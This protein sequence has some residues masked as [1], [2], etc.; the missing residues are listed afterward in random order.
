[1]KQKSIIAVAGLAMLTWSPLVSAQVRVFAKAEIPGELYPGDRFVFAV[2]VENAGKPS[3]IDSTPL[4]RFN[5]SGPTHRHVQQTINFK[6]TIQNIA[7]FVL[8]A[9]APGAVRIAP[10]TVI[11][12]GM[13]YT[14]NPVEFTVA[15]PGTTDKLKL[16]VTLSEQTCYVGQPV[17]MSVA[18]TLPREHDN[19]N[20]QI[21]I[22]QSDDFY[23]EDPV[24]PGKVEGSTNSIHGI[25]VEV[26]SQ[27]KRIKGVAAA[28]I[29]FDKILIPKRH[30]SLSFE[31]V[32]ASASLPVGRVRTND[33][34]QPFR[35]RY[36]RFSVNSPPLNLEVK[37][38]PTDNQPPGY[39]GLVGRYT[40]ATQA[41]PTEVS[42][43]DPITLTIRIGGNPYLKPVRWPDLANV[44]ALAEHFRI[45]SEKASPELQQG[46]K[47]F[48]QT[49]RAKSDQVTAIPAIPL[50]TFDPQAHTYRTLTSAP[51]PLTVAASQVLGSEDLVGFSRQPRNR[52][53][54]AI[55]EGLAANYEGDDALENQRFSLTAMALSPGPLVIWGLPLLSLA[56]SILLKLAYRTSPEQVAA[57]RRRQAA[58]RALQGL[59]DLRALPSADQPEKLGQLLCQYVGDRFGKTAGSLTAQEC[60]ET[61]LQAGI[62]ADLA[63]RLEQVVS[64][65]EAARY[66]SQANEIDQT[67]ERNVQELIKTIDRAAKRI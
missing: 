38:L 56:G 47:V 53:V 28:V 27:T 36:Q 34:F 48:T 30:G 62:A 8:T 31:P 25:P 49:I 45:P 32:T 18:W 37:A 22:F 6:T 11:V 9:P 2:V 17:L 52:E 67:A 66:A 5:P 23:F 4:Q 41:S 65:C 46:H 61:V 44:P 24:L 26:F 33:F 54:E 51:I 16:E 42:V 35:T 19:M 40:I 39:Y 7:S 14:T 64:T 12:D 10:L 59:R 57:K 43:G 13:E 20:I 3:R 29:T 60:R 63:G 15:Q 50:V 58:A 55:R 1:V 21:P